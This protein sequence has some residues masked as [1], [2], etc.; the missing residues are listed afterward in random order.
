M[1]EKKAGQIAVSGLVFALLGFVMS[2]ALGVYVMY[3]KKEDGSEDKKTGS[4]M[5]A[6]RYAPAPQ[7]RVHFT[8][9]PPQ[10]PAPSQTFQ[11]PAMAQPPAGPTQP[12]HLAAATYNAAPLIPATVPSGVV[13]T[14]FDE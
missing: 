9:P 8:Q 12:Y 2:I 3:Y 13:G 7:P 5:Y 6:Y 11:P 1:D 14:F 4:A 10:A